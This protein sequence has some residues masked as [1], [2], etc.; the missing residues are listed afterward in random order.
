[1]NFFLHFLQKTVGQKIIVALTGLGLC[2]FVLIHMLGN[3]FILSGPK[4]YNRYAHSLHEF[5]LITF[6]EIGLLC[7]FVSHILLSVL[8]MHKNT[9]A[10]GEAYSQPAQGDKKTPLVHKVI[11]FQAGVLLVFL[12]FHLQAFKFGPYY[13]G[14][15]DQEPVRDVY[16]LVVKSFKNPLY[17]LGYSFVL[18][19]LFVH[20]L[21]GFSASF[22]TMGLGPPY[23]FLVEKLS[24]L[25]AVT[26]VFGFLVPIWYIFIFL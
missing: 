22:K 13:P 11:W 15:I 23:I 1:M 6:F 9:K 2:L 8:L 12:I 16:K 5:P 26:V 25:L 21:R 20:L 10:R 18:L 14:F 4:A 7:F 24:W 3:L 19:I 17:T